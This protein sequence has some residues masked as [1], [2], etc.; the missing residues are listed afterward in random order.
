MN[1]GSDDQPRCAQASS[2]LSRRHACGASRSGTCGTSVPH[3]SH[4]RS[5]THPTPKVR[6]Q[7][8]RRGSGDVVLQPCRERKTL[9]YE[10]SSGRLPRSQRVFDKLRQVFDV[11]DDLV[12]LAPLQTRHLPLLVLESSA[13]SRDVGQG[14]LDC[15]W[16]LRRFRPAMECPR[17]LRF[18]Q[19][20]IL[21]NTNL[22]RRTA[23]TNRSWVSWIITGW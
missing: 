15:L 21:D 23:L 14:A 5:G 7:T 2:A 18:G 22:E 20:R 19:R 10:Q 4:S 8:F 12:A 11:A 17:D 3:H 6:D 1:A 13:G 16:K 9:R